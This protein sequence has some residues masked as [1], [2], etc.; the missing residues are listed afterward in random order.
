[1]EPSP[2]LARRFWEAVEPLHAV[3]YFAPEPAE[4]ARMLGLP[5]WWMGY[6]AGRVAPLGPLDAPA[7]TSMC[8]GFEPGMVER[9]LPDAWAYTT[10]EAVLSTRLDAVRASLTRLLPPT[11]T[12]TMEPLADLLERAVRAC[13]FDGRPLAAG[14][15]N[16]RRPA[17][18][19][20]RVWL[21]ATVL[22]EHRGDGHVIAAV[23]E[24]LRGLDATLTHVA[25]GAISRELIQPHRGWTD[26]Q[27]ED[28]RRRLTARG[29]LDRTGRL[30]RTGGELRRHIEDTTDRLAADPVSA[31]GE[32]GIEEA[33]RLATPLSRHLI[34]TG[35]I[36]VPNPIGAPR[37]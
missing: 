6:F 13:R 3:A 32:T 30:T 26:E 5:S 2:T 29:L 23:H 12:A 33:I 1:M 11:A 22:R 24:G 37:P 25:T 35:V 19:A 28:S 10:P 8:Y 7:T 31:L 14:W 20:E 18:A 27:W 21:A 4:A 15:A 16:V 34:D 36:P 9:A 17:H